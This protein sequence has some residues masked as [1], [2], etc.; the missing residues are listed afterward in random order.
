ML[1]KKRMNDKEVDNELL[2]AKPEMLLEGMVKNMVD[3]VT[4]K[5]LRQDAIE[6]ADGHMSDDKEMIDEDNTQ[7]KQKKSKAMAR[8]FVKAVSDKQKTG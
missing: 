7:S 3:Q 6:D 5:I 4:K 1:P 8:Q 2:T